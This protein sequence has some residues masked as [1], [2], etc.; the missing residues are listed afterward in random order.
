MKPFNLEEAKAGKPVC[1]R[2]GNAVR[3]ICFDAR[4]SYPIVALVH[5]GGADDEEEVMQFSDTGLFN[6]HEPTHCNDLFMAPVKKTVWINLYS[7]GAHSPFPSDTTY[8]SEEKAKRAVCETWPYLG[9][10]PITYEE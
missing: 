2:D 6:Y 10:F 7:A 9:T 4:Q 1:T 3:I 5:G 8:E